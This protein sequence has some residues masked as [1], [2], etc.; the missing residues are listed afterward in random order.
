VFN[1]AGFYNDFRNQQ[2]PIGV[3]P[4]VTGQAANATGVVNAGASRIWGVEVET[5]LELFRG[6][7]VS[8]SYSYLDTKIT[9]LA[10]PSF[11]DPVYVLDVARA[12]R[13]GDALPFAAK[14]KLS[15]SVAYTLPLDE[16]V[17]EITLGATYTHSDKQITNYFFRDTAGALNGFSY[18]QPRNLLDLNLSWNKI[19]GSPIDLQVFANNVTKQKYYTYILDVNV[20]AQAAQLGLPRMYGFR[21]RYNFSD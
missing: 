13:I 1:V 11:T 18:L 3:S 17:G 7:V 21:L 4:R 12:P 10:Y 9:E 20:G 15:A 14:N 2:I 6:F 19:G 8:G 16:S 5:S